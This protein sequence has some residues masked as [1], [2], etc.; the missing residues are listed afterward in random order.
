MD[1]TCP[2]TQTLSAP[3]TLRAVFVVFITSLFF[4]YEF[5]L[6]NIFNALEQDIAQQYHLNASMMGYV[7]SLYFY[8]NILFLLPAG[9]LIDRYS[10]RK[11]IVS[12]MVACSLSVL[13]VAMS[14]SLLLLMISRFV[15]GLGG[16]FCM[17]GCIRIAANWFDS[18]HMGKATSAIVF[19]GFFGGLM[20]QAPFAILINHVGWRDALMVVALVGFIITVL[21]FFLVKNAPPTLRLRRQTDL[22]NLNQLGLTKSLKLALLKSQNWLCGLY[23]SMNNL[24]VF[25][26]GALWGIPY[27]MKVHHLSNVRAATISLMLFL[28]TMVGSPLFGALSDIIKKRKLPMVLGAIASL[29]LI[30]FV[31]NVHSNNFLL[32]ATLFFLLGVVASAQVLCYPTVIEINSPMITSTATS[33]LSMC[34]LAGGAIV[35]PLF[36]QLLMSH[37]DG[38]MAHGIPSYSIA[39]F[40]YAMNILPIA[41]MISFVASLFIRESY[42]TN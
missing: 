34:L 6:S 20:V 9:A 7:S 27:L 8:A 11:L 18:K 29:I 5:G 28:G 24:P 3:R 12:A 1:A 22:D 42:S 33:I 40:Q 21:I 25:M 2:M 41:F 37:W 13:V 39:S 35:Q 17:V 31:I 23:A 10:P 36:G 14:N 15:M 26:I 4:F 19:M 16:G 30:Y 32:L 38:Q